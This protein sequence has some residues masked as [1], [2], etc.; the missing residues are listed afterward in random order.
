MDVTSLLSAFQAGDDAAACKSAAQYAR[1]PGNRDALG[2]AGVPPLCVAALSGAVTD[3]QL[4][5]GPVATHALRAIGNLCFD[6]DANRAAV[7]EA[8]GAA[9]MAAAAAAIVAQANPS[10]VPDTDGLLAVAVPHLCPA[11][12]PARPPVAE[13]WRRRVAPF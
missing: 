10:A 9:A 4:A 3:G 2:E 13:A 1:E 5:S 11:G 8:G 6:H 7:L 12:H